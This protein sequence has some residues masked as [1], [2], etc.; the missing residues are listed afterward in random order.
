[1]FAA[2]AIFSQFRAPIYH[3][4]ETSLVNTY[5]TIEH[6]EPTKLEL[7]PHFLLTKSVFYQAV[8]PPIA[9]VSSTSVNIIRQTYA[10]VDLAPLSNFF[11][12]DLQEFKHAVSCGVAQSRSNSTQNI[13]PS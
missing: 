13:F 9:F 11:G 8:P 4:F 6:I 7:L 1:L 5:A 3:E 10:E 12:Q 2:E